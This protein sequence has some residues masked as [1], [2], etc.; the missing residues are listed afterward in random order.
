MKKLFPLMMSCICFSGLNA[1]D[2]GIKLYV[3][4]KVYENH[5]MI[6][7][8]KL[9]NDLQ[10]LNFYLGKIEAFNDVLDFLEKEEINDEIN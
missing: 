9:K 2:S 3:E 5:K 10:D 1:Y 7:Q 6:K 8:L 4:S